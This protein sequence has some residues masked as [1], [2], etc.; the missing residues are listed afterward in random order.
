[1]KPKLQGITKLIPWISVLFLALLSWYFLVV[2][3]YDMLF[4]Q[5][6]R[7]LFND[8]ADFYQQ[9]QDK[10]A[11]FLQWAGCFFTQLFYYPELGSSVLILMWIATFFLMKK[12]LRISDALSPALLLPLICLLISEISL[13][14]WIYDNK[15]LGYCFSQTI[16]LLIASAFLLICRYATSVKFKFGNII[17]PVVCVIALTLSYP[18]IGVY[19]LAASS[20]L[21]FMML[22]Q[23]KWIACAI[24][25]IGF[26]GTPFIYQ[27]KFEA[28][29]EAQLFTAGLPA[30]QCGKVTDPSLTSIFEMALTLFTISP[31]LYWLGNRVGNKKIETIFS[32]ILLIAVAGG[33]YAIVNDK[34][35]DDKNF[36]AECKSYRAI[37]EYR[38]DDALSAIR[39][40]DGTLSRQLI[41]F[42][43][44]AL[45]NTNDIGNSM[46]DYDEL[47]MTPILCD[48]MQVQMC[49]TA[50]AIIYLHHG[51]PNYAYRWCMEVQVDMGFNVG[52]LKI[53]VLSSILS[54]ENKIAEKYLNIL[55][56]TLFY[57]EWAEHYRPL[58]RNPKLIGKYPELANI[59]ELYTHLPN[60]CDSDDG[61]CEN[62]L[63]HYF[64]NSYNVKSKYFQ[65][66]ALAYA[67]MTK[68]IKKFWPHYIQYLEYHKGEE[69]SKIYKQ[70][71]CIYN[72][73]EPQST[74]D[75]KTFGIEFDPAIKE[76]YT[77]FD[78]Q[79]QNLLKVGLPEDAIA[80]Q[81][82]AEFG[83]TFWW[84]YYF[85]NGS[86]CY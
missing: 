35:Y 39:E 44:I 15:N 16:G 49:N 72:D 53:M 5:Q 8:T 65:E 1:M 54:G 51:M 70:A 66:M 80:R 83:N 38:W 77:K 64:S 33:S 86:M 13:G 2:R 71:I 74:P 76:Q 84:V 69:I 57:K 50:A 73:L 17:M 26:L 37:D 75:P 61:I 30:F 31:A 11:G 4:M 85:T 45:F 25:F 52:H 79:T 10:P 59:H 14:Y 34:N 40:V 24:F 78:D 43:N 56:H 63:I 22:W 82:K 23:R 6:M 12:G 29:S 68:N 9:Y 67:L 42:K 28:L 18:H 3:N 81:T 47:G 60:L 27:E 48:T 21:G 20:C 46:Y 7:S 36:H 32:I 19:A 41:I 55:S 62:Y 58:A